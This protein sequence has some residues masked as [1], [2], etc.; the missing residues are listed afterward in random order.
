MLRLTGLL[1][2]I[3]VTLAVVL[4]AM[5]WS[6]SVRAVE[7]N[8][9][10]SGDVLLFPYYTARQGEA[11]SFVTLLTLVNESERIKAARVRFYEG[12]QGRPVLEF[13]VYLAPRDTWVG[14]VLPEGSGAG[15]VT[16]DSSCTD[17]ALSRDDGA[18][19]SFGK[20]PVTGSE[21]MPPA[22][23]VEGYIE[24]FQLGDYGTG[25]DAPSGSVAAAIL[26][27]SLSGQ[28]EP[29]ECARVRSDDG[30]EAAWAPGSLAGNATYI[31]VFR[32]LEL[33]QPAVAL[34]DFVASRPSWYRPTRDRPTL[35]DAQPSISLVHRAG[36]GTIRTQWSRQIEAVTAVL[37][38][39]AVTGEFV[40]DRA[41]AS[42]S[43][44]LLTMP[45]RRH[46]VVPGE[47]PIAPFVSPVS[48]GSPRCE[49]TASERWGN[50]FDRTGRA[51]PASGG[52]LSPPNPA[53]G[54][55]WSTTAIDFGPSDLLGSRFGWA[56][57]RAPS[58]SGAISFQPVT[59]IP[60]NG[61]MRVPLHLDELPPAAPPGQVLPSHAITGGATTILRSDGTSESLPSITIHGL[62]VIGFYASTFRNGA[63]PLAS[64]PV[65][66]NYGSALP[67]RREWLMR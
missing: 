65:L 18:P 60:E 45:T 26:S 58:G 10:G 5:V 59:Q 4:F 28:A 31:D 52:F 61:W 47:P 21:Q 37:M 32:A 41:T 24:V 7:W 51:L 50:L 16:P 33:V 44:W 6:S 38:T 11:G 17:P 55:C 48:D 34:V 57:M 39:S 54:L 27:A 22:E 40:L 30:S 15:I 64:G 66:A 29:T 36:L 49:P 1:D 13:V 67:L 56:F 3:R 35:A 2:R 43:A 12:A 8:P 42:Q 14:A 19:T 9:A 46:H 20:D 23:V 63:L 62:P 53:R 25:A